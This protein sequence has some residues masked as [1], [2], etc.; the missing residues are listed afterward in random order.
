MELETD[1]AVKAVGHLQGSANRR[2]CEQCPCR[3]PLRPD[4]ETIQRARDLYFE[5][6]LDE[7][8]REIVE[9]LIAG[10]IETYESCDGGEG[11]AY[12]EPTVRF[13]GDLSEG[14]RAVSVAL[15]N[16]LPVKMLRRAWSIRSGMLHGPWWEMT[17]IPP[18]PAEI[19][20]Q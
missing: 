19:D 6:P 3:T 8:I 20:S 14:P 16:G 18:R 5:P 1:P 4:S 12:A 10:G 15:A 7:G 17:F 9:T 11:H 2:L 13:E